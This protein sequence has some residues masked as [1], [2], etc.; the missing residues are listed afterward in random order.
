M[1]SRIPL[2]FA[3]ALAILAQSPLVAHAQAAQVPGRQPAAA[4]GSNSAPAA[5]SP[6]EWIR[7]PDRTL[8][9][10]VDEVSTD[11]AAA[12]AALTRKDNAAAVQSMKAAA[13]ALNTDSERAAQLQR[14]AAAEGQLARQ[15]Q[16][17][18]AAAATR[19]DAVAALVEAGKV[20]GAAQVD[21][22]LGKA[23]RADLEQRWMLAD[24]ATWY[25]VAQEPERHFGAA[26]EDFVKQDSHAAATEVR[27]A[28]AYLRLESARAAGDAKRELEAANAALDRTAEALDRGAVRS[29]KQLARVFAQASHA[30]AL[31]HRAEAAD[32]WAHRAYA[33][34]GYELKA[35]AS[36]AEN[37]AI[38]ASDKAQS[39]ELVAVDDAHKVGDKLASGTNWTRN[40]VAQGFESLGG[41][42]DQIGHSIGAK[43][44]AS[45]FSSGA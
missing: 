27:K 35:A 10:V 43:S 40:E 34:A 37:A 19:L 30:L 18:L 26:I 12:R 41:A 22:T 23:M 33:D 42:L 2:N 1:N 13:S 8:T 15:T 25:P 20:A 24:V 9:P 7:Y 3:I 38:W 11:L 6:T 5:N 17:R 44:K 31:S 28:A 14:H 16:T 39:A 21:E 36:A 32:S 45:S 29:E 4:S